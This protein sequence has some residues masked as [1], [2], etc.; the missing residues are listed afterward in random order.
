MAI[1]DSELAHRLLDGLRGIEVGG[2]A[3]NPFNIPGCIN[4]DYTGSADT[5]F[6]QEERALSGEALPV[7]VVASGERLPFAGE[8]LDFVLSSHVLEHFWDPIAALR[9]WLRVLKPGGLIFAVIPHKERTMDRER[10]RTPFDE[11]L[12]RHAGAAAPPPID[13]HRHWSVW[14]AEDLREI[15]ERLG[16]ELAAAQD[17]DD[18]VGNGFTVVLRKP[19]GY[20]FGAS[21]VG[22]LLAE[23]GGLAPRLPFEGGLLDARG[24]LAACWRRHRGAIGARG[25]ALENR[26]D[27]IVL[28]ALRGV[29]ADDVAMEAALEVAPHARQANVGLLA[30]YS[31][32]ADANFYMACLVTRRDA[33]GWAVQIVR[34]VAGQRSVLA[35]APV[36]APRGRLGLLARARSLCASWN[37]E[38]VARASDDALSAGRVGFRLRGS[39]PG[40]VRFADFVCRAAQA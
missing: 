6:K 39:E 17:P 16:L 34:D 33:R 1:R 11:L 32:L 3:H 25:R 29:W 21:S 30:R 12:D 26:D 24:G 35:S 4:V 5:A 38:V 18:K 28:A 20:D 19:A 7:H 36:D 31:G 37:G 15:G 9:E 8:S 27:E 13:D 14:V 10:A 22:A 40:T 2:S 23:L